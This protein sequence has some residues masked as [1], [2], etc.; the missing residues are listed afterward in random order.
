MH[1][2][3][4]KKPDTNVQIQ[5]LVGRMTGYWK[6]IVMDGH[7]TGP[8][9]T[10]IVSILQYEKFYQNPENK[11]KYQVNLNKGIFL[12][13][14]NVGIKNDLVKNF[15]NKQIPIII[16]LNLLDPEYLI[17][18]LN[19]KNEKIEYLKKIICSI[20][21]YTRLFNFISK[22]DPNVICYGFIKPQTKT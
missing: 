4:C 3:Y 17:Y 13:A 12:S 22:S 20:K 21:K 18:Y 5:G 9:R 1:E 19:S 8:Y 11:E 16:N 2:R 15:E 6:N 7:K 10:C 14:K